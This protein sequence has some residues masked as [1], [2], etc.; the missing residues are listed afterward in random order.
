MPTVSI[1]TR[2]YRTAG[3][4]LCEDNIIE[5]SLKLYTQYPDEFHNIIVPHE[6]AHIITDKI[7]EKTPTNR[8]HCTVWKDVMVK[9]GL[10]PNI[11]HSMEYRK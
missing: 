2:T 9:Y 10:K 7:N 6:L 8:H 11:Y 3:M 4:A 1:N 5:F